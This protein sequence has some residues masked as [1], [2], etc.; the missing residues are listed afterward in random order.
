MKKDIKLIGT[1]SHI[2]NKKA[3]EE[4]MSSEYISEVRFNT[5]VN[6]LLEEKKI[7]EILKSLEEKFSKK[8]WIDLKGRQLRVNSWADTSYEA[9]ELNHKIDIE[10]PAKVIFRG[11]NTSNIIHTKGNKIILEEPPERAVG[12]GQSVNVKAKSLIIEGYLTQLDKEFI[13]KSK[14]LG[15]NNYM[16]SFLESFDDLVEILSLNTN[17][18]IVAKIES[19]KGL[20]FALSNNIAIQPMAARDDLWLECKDDINVL[21]ALQEIIKKYPSAICASRLFSSL[22]KESEISLSDM[23]DLELMYLYG[24]KTFMLQDEIQGPKLEKALKGWRSF[25]YE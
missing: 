2:H 1:L 11:G 6:E 13:K 19:L 25:L 15:M 21:K 23:E 3:V 7:I 9:I 12:K 24:Y 17:A 4:M 18:T 10:Y 16:A 5:G 20:R 14:E 8:I 22:N